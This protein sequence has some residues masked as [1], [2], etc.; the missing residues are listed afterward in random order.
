MLM[1]ISFLW[2]SLAWSADDW[3]HVYL[4]NAEYAINI[5]FQ[6]KF[7][8]EDS[9]QVTD[10]LYLNLYY[11]SINEGDAVEAILV[12]YSSSNQRVASY[13]CDQFRY[14]SSPVPH[15]SVHIQDCRVKLQEQEEWSWPI[16]PLVVRRSIKQSVQETVNHQ[17]LQVQ[18]KKARKIPESPETPE[19]QIVTIID[20]WSQSS[21]FQ[22]NLYDAFI[23][24]YQKS[25]R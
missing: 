20:P 18:I 4:R 9:R 3:S 22:L 19:E 2:I 6:V 25:A 5:D 15:F 23:A 17:T 21:I 1:L 24:N 14:Y 13:L 12:N 11:Q 8:R 16:V 7:V 10:E